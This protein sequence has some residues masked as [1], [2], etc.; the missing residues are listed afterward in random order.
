MAHRSMK[1]ML[2]RWLKG[3]AAAQGAR[4]HRARYV[5]DYQSVVEHLLGKHDREEAL[6]LA[7]GGN[8]AIGDSEIGVLL[9]SGLE[10]DGHLVDVGCGSGRL[11]RRAAKLPRLRYLG[12]DINATLLDE[13]R[14]TAARKDFRYVL[15]DGIAIPERDS[16]ADMVA[17]FSVGTH[18]LHEEFYVYLRDARRV[19]K[20]GGRIVLSF[21]DFQ[22]VGTW[23][24]FE[25]MLNVAAAGSGGGH[26]NMFIGRDDI[27]VWA[28]QLD[29]TVIDVVPGDKQTDW[30]T[31]ASTALLGQKLAPFAFGQSLAILE[32][33]A[34]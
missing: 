25:E 12:T 9:R 29:M 5:A 2:N 33:P 22:C 30:A 24:V 8:D 14:R 27:R 10:G 11:T 18:L 32:K 19:L 31:E 20:P 23:A 6:L 15:V 28:R 21:L 17:F 3:A 34:A 16:V 1:G 4:G 7:V 13:A 26:L